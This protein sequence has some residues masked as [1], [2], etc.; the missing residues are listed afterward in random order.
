[1]QASQL[2]YAR[3]MTNVPR[4]PAS[5]RSRSE[6]DKRCDQYVQELI[7]LNPI[8]GQ[9]MGI[10]GSAGSLP[11]YSSSGIAKEI[12]LGQALLEWARDPAN[13]VHYDAV[14]LVT[15]AALE[16]RLTLDRDLYETG[17]FERTLNSLASP[18]QEVR[19]SFDLLPKETSADWS[20]ICDQSAS[21]PRALEGFRESLSAAAARGHVAAKRQV[22]IAIQQADSAADLKDPSSSFS[23]LFEEGRVRSSHP[24]KL[25]ESIQLASTA[26]AQLAHWLRSELLPLAPKEDAVGPERYKRLSDLFIGAR[27]DLDETYEWGLAELQEIEQQQNRLAAKLYGKGTSVKEAMLRL[28]EEPDLTLQGKN[29]LRE[30]MQETADTA[31]QELN[32]TEFEIPPELQRIE[33]MLAP[34]GNGGIYYTGPSIDFSR[35]GR[36]WWSVPAGVERFHTWQERTTVFHEGAPG[37]HLQIGLAMLSPKVPNVWRKHSA[38]NSGHGEGWA[39]YAEQLMVELGYQS[40]PEDLMGVADAQRFR[41]ARVVLDI[42]IHL[43]KRIPGSSRVWDAEYAEDFLAANTAMDASFRQFELNRY[44]GWPGQ[45]PSYK[46]GQ[47]LW[48]QLR[49]DYIATLPDSLAPA[50]KRKQFHGEALGLGNL[51]MSILRDALLGRQQ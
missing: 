33:C 29:A 46:V 38:W 23:M 37:H 18:L 31:I 40:R 9:E 15:E 34:S 17:E 25:Q 48:E 49:A 51:P 2:A 22:L 16:N 28:D 41:A 20:H 50:E 30:W 47:R 26:Y 14:D 21:V 36:M 39:L 45:A 32:G 3:G 13:K 19:D 6:L 27:V 11:D 8:V 24:E 4:P 10:E 5:E 44:L 42:G 35:P 43:K 1:M 7:K 12:E